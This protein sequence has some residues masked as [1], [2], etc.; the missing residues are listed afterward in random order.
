[1][2]MIWWDLPR[3]QWIHKCHKIVSQCH[4][5]FLGSVQSP[6]LVEYLIK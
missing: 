6:Y 2:G 1:M 3:Q 5:F 4:F